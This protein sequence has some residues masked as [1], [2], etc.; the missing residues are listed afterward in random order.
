MSFHYFLYIQAVAI[1]WLQAI[2]G[3][4]LTRKGHAYYTKF[5][6]N[7]KQLYR[8]AAIFSIL[9]IVR[10]SYQAISKCTSTTM[11]C[12]F[13]EHKHACVQKCSMEV[14]AVAVNSARVGIALFSI[15]RIAR[16][17]L[18]VLKSILLVP[19]PYETFVWVKSD[20]YKENSYSFPSQSLMSISVVYGAIF[21][22][23]RLPFSVYFTALCFVSLSRVYRGLHYPYDVIF[24]FYI[25]DALQRHIL[26]CAVV[27]KNSVYI[28]C[29]LVASAIGSIFFQPHTFAGEKKIKK[30]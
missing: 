9:H 30:I 4:P 11:A 20:K 6:T 21:R 22:I 25:G 27:G 18:H 26:D 23:F 17:A 7:E 1:S 15:L 24:S 13:A 12:F 16:P 8:A 14:L 19:R 10:D 28:F 3:P 2:F 29:F 5:I